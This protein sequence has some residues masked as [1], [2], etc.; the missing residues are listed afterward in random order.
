M[1]QKMKYLSFFIL[2]GL[3][4]A[5]CL[6][7]PAAGAAIKGSNVW[8]QDQG[9]STSYT[10]TPAMYSGLWY[11]YDTGVNTENITLTISA[12][13]RQIN[14]ENAQYITE[15]KNKSFAY[16]DWGSYRAIGWLGE[17]YFA[18]YTRANSSSNTTQFVSSNVS[19]LSDER[20]YPVLLD[21]SDE[22]S[23][24]SGGTYTLEN[25]YKLIISDINESSKQF[26][27]TLERNGNS[28]KNET[29][30]NNTTFV[31]ERSL[32]GVGTVAVLAVHVKGV[33]GSKAVINGAFQI[34]ESSTDVSEGKTVGAMEVTAVNDTRIT[35]KN[36]SRIKLNEG[37][38]VTLMSH[39]KIDVKDT[40]K[41][42]FELISDPK[43]DSE[44]EYPNR[45]AVY[46]SSNTIKSWN[47]MNFGGFTYDYNNSTET[48]NLSFDVSGSLSRSVSAGKIMYQTN[49]Y[50][51]SFNYSGWGSYQAINLG[52][53]N[54]FAGYVRYSSSNKNN[55]TN[56]TDTNDSILKDGSVAKVLINNGT[57]KQY[58]KG[59]NISLEEGY[60]IQVSNIT[61]NGTKANLILTK[62]GTT[63]K[64][65]TVSQGENFVY[66]AS[67]GGT[68]V[69]IIAVRIT[70][71][72]E[73]SSAFIKVGGIFQISTDTTD[74]SS[75]KTID[76]MRIEYTGS[77]ALIFVNKN[78][79]NLTKGADIP[80]MENLSLHVADS[81]D[82]R[83]FPFNK[84][85]GNN[86]STNSLKIEVPATVYPNDEITIKVLYNDSGSWKNLSAA[87]VKING[88][89]IGETN[90]SGAIS[91][92]LNGSGSYE[93]RAEK[94]GYQSVTL[95]K[96]TSEGGEELVIEIPD[97]I[98][99]EDSFRLYVKGANGTNISGAGVYKDSQHIGTTNDNGMI[100]VTA[101]ST[102]GEYKLTANKTGYMTG[103]VNMTIL[104][105]G[106][107]FAVTDITLPEE[108][109]AGKTAKI[110]MTVEN[111]GKEKDTQE[112]T[113]KSGNE[114]E[115]K[116][117]TLSPGETKNITVSFKP[118]TAG[119]TV[120]E[121]TNQS[122]TYTVTEKPKTEIPWKWIMLGGGFLIILLGALM[123]FM[124][125]R[126]LA[127][128]KK[129]NPKSANRTSRGREPESEGIIDKIIGK[130][131]TPSEKKEKASSRGAQASGRSGSASN[132]KSSN[133]QASKPAASAPSKSNAHRF[134]SS[135]KTP[136][137]K[138]SQKKAR[139][140]QEKK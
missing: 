38:T 52:G 23:F 20:I 99:T 101:D 56:F 33:D 51:E 40:S 76:N 72:F 71:V 16:S 12:S 18:G 47:G 74:V 5:A 62:N 2:I 49:A 21:N 60:V 66:E 77:S 109:F 87:T 68:V 118:Q 103:T 114:T 124:Y 88:T 92:T 82:L 131:N 15:Y 11:D 45:G 61:S 34:S 46:D 4:S 139:K 8:D 41:L 102:T 79:I 30:S 1:L 98:F 7:G 10:W 85:S 31:Y 6:A 35:M 111:V 93:F 13:D 127:E 106:P 57:E 63:V 69:P 25:G 140:D 44:K 104:E 9:M 36:P 55:T 119:E 64:E 135:S 54:Y 39:I 137:L 28:V 84:S 121:V 37:N 58:N 126:E 133:A 53:E 110:A 134:S 89:T 59:T 117:I 42:K 113:I 96:S 105:Y 120:I 80:L 32:D 91:Y 129:N 83:F 94:S 67:V 29:V 95:T 78:D 132:A 107:Y 70:N 122:F 136:E 125:Y 128:E 26:R 115:T 43:T 22:K 108:T 50:N 73:S 19:T 81:D 17:P 130:F 3:I 138:N 90:S 75:G 116:K 27:L 100:N 86:T 97:Y 14:A 24:S 48:E 112:I 123:A 65:A